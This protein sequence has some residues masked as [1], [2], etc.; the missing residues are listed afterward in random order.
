MLF[1]SNWLY[2]RVV[3]SHAA[4]MTSAFLDSSV[5]RALRRLGLREVT[6]QRRQDLAAVMHLCGVSAGE[7]FA[8]GR[9][10]WASAPLCG[11]QDVRAYVERLRAMQRQFAALA[12]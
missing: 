6:L 11:G 12:R 2:L 4:E 7:A 5:Q 8:R 1:R 3:P 10:R 9:F